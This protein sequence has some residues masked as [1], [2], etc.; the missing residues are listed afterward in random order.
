VS[1]VHA[2]ARAARRPSFWAW[3]ALSALPPDLLSH[4]FGLDVVDPAYLVVCLL[5]WPLDVWGRLEAL[6]L[7]LAESGLE[8]RPAR[9]ALASCLG[10][11]ILLSLRCS[12]LI[13]AG[14]LPALALF[15]LEGKEILGS[16]IA[17]KNGHPAAGNWALSLA[18]AGLILAGLLPV[19]LYILRRLSAPQELLLRPLRSGEALDQAA[20]RTRGRLGALLALALPWA[21]LGW[22]LDLIGL[23]L[24][25]SLSLALELPSLAA[26]L[27]AVAVAGALKERPN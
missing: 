23:A 7:V 4:A 1:P 5:W 12:V 10:A 26:G 22:G 16:L 2:L 18:W 8:V 27:A 21:A 15:S 6:R 13:L 9:T 17:L 25:D 11:E 24:P 3:L 14:M 19:T 20:A